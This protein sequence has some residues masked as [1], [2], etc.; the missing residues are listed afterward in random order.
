MS[1]RLATNRTCSAGVCI[2]TSGRQQGG[3]NK[4]VEVGSLFKVVLKTNKY[5][6]IVYALKH[7]KVAERTYTPYSSACFQP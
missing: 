1:Q 4:T 2:C 3:I 7:T 6:K 5:L